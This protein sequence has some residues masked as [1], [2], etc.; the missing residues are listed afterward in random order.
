[1]DE[2][3]DVNAL[4]LSHSYHSKPPQDHRLVRTVLLR[5]LCFPFCLGWWKQQVR[6]S[7]VKRI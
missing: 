4:K 7:A 5:T 1:M 6:A 3:L 2:L